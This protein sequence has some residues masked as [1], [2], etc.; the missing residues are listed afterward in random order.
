MSRLTGLVRGA[1]TSDI[2]GMAPHTTNHTT[3]E[4]LQLARAWLSS[5]HATKI[6]SSNEY[7]TLI[8]FVTRLSVTPTAP[9]SA[10]LAVAMCHVQ[11]L[12]P[13]PFSHATCVGARE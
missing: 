7:P 9:P 11:P 10:F 2:E 8:I 5:K 12:T 1:D 4:S 13:L 3:H 6:Y